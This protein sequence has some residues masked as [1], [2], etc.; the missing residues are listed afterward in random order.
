MGEVRDAASDKL[1]EVRQQRRANLGQLRG[2]VEAAA[3]A[4]KL[5]G[6]SE[7]G[8]TSII[9]DRF[10]VGVKVRGGALSIAGVGATSQ[11]LIP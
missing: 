9:R 11:Q 10:C 8:T 6:A 2:V 4:M 3:A 1:A 5:L 7:E